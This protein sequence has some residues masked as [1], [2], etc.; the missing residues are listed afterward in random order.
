MTGLATQTLVC[1]GPPSE[2][3][4]LVAGHPDVGVVTGL[5]GWPLSLRMPLC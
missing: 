3:F 1:Y 4:I 5:A 2:N